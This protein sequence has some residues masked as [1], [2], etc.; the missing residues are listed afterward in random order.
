MSSST[1]DVAPPATADGRVSVRTLHRHLVARTGTKPLDWLNAQRVRRAQ[2]LLETTDLTIE[3]IATDRG[4]GSA[5]TL[6]RHFRHTLATSPD[7][8]RRTFTTAPAG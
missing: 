3:R 1:F 7:A 2:Q 5:A 8:Y 4:F 6:R